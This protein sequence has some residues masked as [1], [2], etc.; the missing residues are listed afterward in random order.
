MLSI[1]RLIEVVIGMVSLRGHEN[2][3]ELSS[4]HVKIV[5][6][7]SSSNELKIISVS[8][9][10]LTD[11]ELILSSVPIHEIKIEIDENLH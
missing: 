7:D 10:M 11:E 5:F 4:F 9:I 3:D 6:L 8:A 1:R 2:E